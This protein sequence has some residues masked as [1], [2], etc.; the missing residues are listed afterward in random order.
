[1]T[2]LIKKNGEKSYDFHH[3]QASPG[4]NFGSIF[5]LFQPFLPLIPL[6]LGRWF[7]PAHHPRSASPCFSLLFSCINMLRSDY[8][9]SLPGER[10]ENFVD[11][12][13]VA[14]PSFRRHSTAQHANRGRPDQIGIW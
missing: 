14:S 4:I 8:T 10:H 12:L 13:V 2:T 7:R 9:V 11:R 1:M 6:Y 5:R 3:E